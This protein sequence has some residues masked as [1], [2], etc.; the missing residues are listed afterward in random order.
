VSGA[1]KVQAL[2]DDILVI[3]R[4][5][6]D[7]HKENLI[8][9]LNFGNQYTNLAATSESNSALKVDV[10]LSRLNSYHEVK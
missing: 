4:D 9:I 2:S 6:N 3:K 8:V 7:A 5:L 1:L 10:Q